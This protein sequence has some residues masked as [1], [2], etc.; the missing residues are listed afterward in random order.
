MVITENAS[1]EPL[2]VA[3]VPEDWSFLQI[4]SAGEYKNNAFTI[5]GR[6]RLQLRNDYKNFWCAVYSTG[7]CLWIAES[8]GSF[9]VF[10]TSW[11]RYKNDATKL[12]AGKTIHLGGN[13]AMQGEY[14]ER[15]ENLRFEGEIGPW[16]LFRPGFFV[17]QA[18]RDSGETA[19]FTIYRDTVDILTG[20]RVSSEDLKLTNI[21]EWNEWK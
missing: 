11:Q 9:R 7:K 10:T 3:K 13:I 2:L 12:R 17:V 21:L 14:V 8:F 15:C 6:V 1:D 19:I 5:V 4:G 16:N 20:E 18:S